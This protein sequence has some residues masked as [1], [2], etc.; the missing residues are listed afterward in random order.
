MGSPHF[1]YQTAPPQYRALYADRKIDLR[2]NVSANERE[3]AIRDLRGY[4]AHIA[5]LDDCMEHL[6]TTLERSGLAEDT[7]VVF[8]SDHGDMMHSQGLTTKTYPWEESARVPFLLRYPRRLGVYGRELGV[9]FNSPDIMPTLLGL[10]GIEIPAGV[11]G[12]DYSGVLLGQAVKD[13]PASAFMN[14]PA[15]FGPARQ[16]GF[17][18]YRG[19]RTSTHTYVRSIHGPWLLYDNRRDPYQMHNL[20]G[21]SAARGTQAALELELEN[22]LARLGDEF[23]PGEVY[24]KRAGLTNYFEVNQPIGHASSPWGDWKS[25]L[26]SN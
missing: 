3:V 20:C 24:L 16:Y 21:Q 7:V 9:P 2:P 12:T 17:A 22:W 18:A 6:L 26:L 13:L 4:Y 11:Q 1:P 10:T 23:L 19:V 25:T 15:S 14:M 5:A 8:T